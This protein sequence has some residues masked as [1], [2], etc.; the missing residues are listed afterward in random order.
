MYEILFNIIRLTF[1][2]FGAF[3]NLHVRLTPIDLISDE[4]YTQ[5]NLLTDLIFLVLLL[6]LS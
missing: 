4:T 3:L 5:L 6:P 1:I 2:E